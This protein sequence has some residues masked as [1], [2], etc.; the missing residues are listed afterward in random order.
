MSSFDKT[1][2]VI[3]PLQQDCRGESTSVRHIS[4]PVTQFYLDDTTIHRYRCI[5]SAVSCKAVNSVLTYFL[6][7]DM[8]P[9]SPHTRR[10]IW[11]EAITVLFLTS[12]E[13]KIPYKQP[14]HYIQARN[15][16]FPA[17][18]VNFQGSPGERH[19]ENIKVSR[20]GLTVCRP[21]TLVVNKDPSRSRHSRLS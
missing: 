8:S 15:S 11:Q 19:V 6:R 3:K 12:P 4:I 16:E 20:S 18:L 17:Y 13:C 1:S 10:R 7:L 5:F 9:S 2:I 14:V 21:L